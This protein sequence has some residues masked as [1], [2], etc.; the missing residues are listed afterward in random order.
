MSRKY[1]GIT[2]KLQKLLATMILLFFITAFPSHAGGAVIGNHGN[3]TTGI[4]FVMLIAGEEKVLQKVVC[5]P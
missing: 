5:L 3:Y 1:G 4:Y 2:M